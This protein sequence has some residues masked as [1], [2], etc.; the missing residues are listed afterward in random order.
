[1]FD[2]FISERDRATDLQHNVAK[3]ELL[4]KELTIALER[5]QEQLE[6]EERRRIAERS[7]AMERAESEDKV[8]TDHPTSPVM[9]DNVMSGM[10]RPN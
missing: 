5:A 1:M 9:V 7:R 3:L 2:K 6:S 10:N 4:N 8:E